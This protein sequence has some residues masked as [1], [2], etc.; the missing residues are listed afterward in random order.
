[1]AEV[2]VSPSDCALAVCIPLT[3][4]AF[5][6]DA[7]SPFKDFARLVSAEMGPELAWSTIYQ[8]RVVATV[9]RVAKRLKSQGSHVVEHAQLGD[10]AALAGRYRVVALLTHFKMTDVSANDVV[11]AR[12]CLEV[13]QSGQDAIAR[14]LRDRAAR[15]MPE[16]LQESPVPHWQLVTR[17]S[18]FLQGCVQPTH[19]YY[20]RLPSH[21]RPRSES[22]TGP[23]L[24]RILLEVCFA[25]ALR[26]APCV[27]TFDGLN[28]FQQFQAAIPADFSGVLDLS[29]CNSFMLG[30]QVKR[31]RPSCLVVE[32]AFLA[33]PEFRLAR[34]SLIVGE[35]SRERSRYTDALVR[36]HRA[37]VE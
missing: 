15:E 16:L 7:A 10:I 6:R 33:T 5:R 22:G 35:L 9:E 2:A 31:V 21:A 4:N 3:Q 14:A 18:S 23:G 11:D 26:S 36:V 20:A 17:V 30:E 12:R 19:D 29:M 32:N 27:E 37:L 13:I 34:Y 8:P 25:T 1:M 28:T 24:H